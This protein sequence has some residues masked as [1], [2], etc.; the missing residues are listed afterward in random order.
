MN[1]GDIIGQISSL[2]GGK[3]GGNP[4]LARGGGG[5][6]DQIE[7]ALKVGRERIAAAIHG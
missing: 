4:T 3:G 1:A 7:L 2:L 5:N 6:I